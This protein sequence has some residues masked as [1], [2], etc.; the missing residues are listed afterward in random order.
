MSARENEERLLDRCLLASRDDFAHAADQREANVFC[1]AA[2][3][4]RSQHPNEAHCLSQAGERYFAEHPQDRL[5]SS[6]VLQNGW[7]ISLPRLRDM[8]SF[9][10]SRTQITR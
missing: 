4:L 1:L 2:T 5:A 10:L 9:K 6:L 8:L 7:I 3:V